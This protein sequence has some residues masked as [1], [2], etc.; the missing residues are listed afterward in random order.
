MGPARNLWGTSQSSGED[1]NQSDDPGPSERTT[2]AGLQ[3]GRKGCLN[4]IHG[5]DR[6]NSARA[7]S[8]FGNSDGGILYGA[9]TVPTGPTLATAEIERS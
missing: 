8:G 7:V 3:A 6:K 4:K 9:L 1:G 5:D 2:V